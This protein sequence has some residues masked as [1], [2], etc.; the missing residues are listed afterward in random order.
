MQEPR[1]GGPFL[2]GYLKREAHRSLCRRG[3]HDIQNESR[4]F[5]ATVHFAHD[6]QP[7]IA[8]RTRNVPGCLR[9]RIDPAWRNPGALLPCGNG[10]RGCDGRNANPPRHADNEGGGE[11]QF[12]DSN[13]SPSPLLMLTH[14][15]I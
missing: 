7:T 14:P 11:H 10:R 6:E 2:D 4:R 1:Q 13:H 5:F 9:Q 8:H 3:A 12:V 15:G